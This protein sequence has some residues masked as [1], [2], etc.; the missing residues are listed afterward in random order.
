MTHPDI[1]EYGEMLP[2]CGLQPMSTAPHIGCPVT[3]KALH[4]ERGEMRVYWSADY[5]YYL[6][7]SVWVDDNSDGV[8]YPEEEFL[9]WLK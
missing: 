4:N 8:C 6:G 9:G 2:D 7:E 3:I 5:M 1:I